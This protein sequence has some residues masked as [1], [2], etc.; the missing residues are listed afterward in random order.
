MLVT[1]N[2]EICMHWRYARS[3]FNCPSS[4][5]IIFTDTIYVYLD[6]VNTLHI[7]ASCLLFVVGGSVINSFNLCWVE[8]KSRWQSQ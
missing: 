5:E 2:E 4:Q 6:T 7:A 3:I 8:R 1:Y